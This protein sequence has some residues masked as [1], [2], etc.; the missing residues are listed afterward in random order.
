[1]V[2][3]TQDRMR[4]AVLLSGEHMQWRS[5][6]TVSVMH[7]SLIPGKRVR[8]ASIPSLSGVTMILKSI[9]QNCTPSQMT[10][11]SGWMT[12]YLRILPLRGR[13]PRLR[14]AFYLCS[15]LVGLR[16]QRNI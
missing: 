7:T 16:L 9:Q 10:F 1:M 2:C 5:I 8:M 11:P 15:L 6:K 14:D 12:I 4:V 13:E 3:C